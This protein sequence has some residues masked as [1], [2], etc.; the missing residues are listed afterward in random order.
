MNAEHLKAVDP[1]IYE[2]V[3]SE[4]ERERKKILLIAS[5]NY[6][7]RAVMDAQGS[8]F[9]NKYA[10]GY[11]GRRY[12]GGCEFADRVER[13]AIGRAKELFGA[14]HVNVQ[15]HSGS[16]ANMAVYFS[17]LKP[18]DTILGMDLK[19]GGH[20]SHGSSVNFTGMIYKSVSYCVQK[21]TGYIDMDGVRRLAMEHKPKIVVVGASAYSRIIDFEAFS[22]I[23]K[24]TG[25]Y[26]MADIAHIAGLIAA[27]V[28]PSPVPYADF[29]T[30]TTHKTLRGPRG[31]LIM[32]KAE[33]AKAIDKMI[34]PGIQGGP[35]VQVIAAKAVAFKEAL[36]PRFKDYQRQVLANAKRLA[37]ALTSKGFTVISGG[38]DNHL[39]LVDLTNMNV[40]GK[41]AEEALDKTGVTVN[42]NGI[43]YDQKPAT[44]TSGIRLGTPCVTTRGMGE[45][46]ME[47][48]ADIIYSVIRNIDNGSLLESAGLR[49][50]ALCEKF[51][52]YRP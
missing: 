14:D 22:A 16:Q 32:C 17:V 46:E 5:E 10:E 8:V 51:P 1:E 38:T 30:S 29:V 49:V 26:L 52:I 50:Q 9:T 6:A 48:I 33:F 47:E 20:L 34:F 11:P 35:L 15:P 37:S 24:E 19:H 7:S 36:L 39:M 41:D 12:Y 21:E 28:H 27:G 45:A 23:A 13:L 40:T 31:G 43:P 4:E 18:G 44:I 25:A 3:I 42:K 2:A